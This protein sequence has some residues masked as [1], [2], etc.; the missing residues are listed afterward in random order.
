MTLEEFLTRKGKSIGVSDWLTV[1]QV[2]IDTFGAVTRD[3]EPMHNDPIWCVENS[4]FG[5]P[6]AYGFQTISML[7][8]LMHSATA[9]L[10]SGEVGELNFP[11]NYG[12]NRLRLLSPV[13]VDDR[14]RARIGLIDFAEKK[15]GELLST[16]DVVVEIEGGDRP[17]LV[18]EWL[19]YWITG[20]GRSN[21]G[22]SLSRHGLS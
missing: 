18:A 7:T 22:R 12:F 1:R 6:I 17:A 13:R 5:K 20:E 16:L 9:S 8:A 21:V 19:V 3:I 14:I 10:F 4:P 11:L 2:D 15:S